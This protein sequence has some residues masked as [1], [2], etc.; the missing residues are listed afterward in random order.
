MKSF[1]NFYQIPYQ[2]II[3]DTYYIQNFADYIQTVIQGYEFKLGLGH[4]KENEY[5]I[6]KVNDF[7]RTDKYIPAEFHLNIGRRNNDMIGL[8]TNN[9]NDNRVCLRKITTNNISKATNIDQISFD[10]KEFL[11]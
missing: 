9:I 4:N 1:S 7:N 6:R 2:N 8:V 10:S 5:D 3:A 11:V